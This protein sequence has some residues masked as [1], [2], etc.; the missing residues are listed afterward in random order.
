MLIR[1]SDKEGATSQNSN[2]YKGLGLCY[3]LRFRYIDKKFY[4]TA[5]TFRLMNSRARVMAATAEIID[6][7]EFRRRRQMATQSMAPM[8]AVVPGTWVAVWFFVP[9]WVGN[10]WPMNR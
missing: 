3:Q 5:Y 2:K 8:P 10:A 9:V 1:T 7:N 6:L 4:I